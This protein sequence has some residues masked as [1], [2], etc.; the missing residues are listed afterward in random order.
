MA[1]IPPGA[2]LEATRH[3]LAALGH[4]TRQQILALLFQE[5]S[6]LSYNEIAE[7]LRLKE[8]NYIDRHLKLLVGASLADNILKRVDGRIRSFYLISPWGEEW[9]VRLKFSDPK[10]VRMLLQPPPSVPSRRAHA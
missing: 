3:A 6:G 4:P 1:A 7:R 9:M 2:E 10:V 5:K 8:A